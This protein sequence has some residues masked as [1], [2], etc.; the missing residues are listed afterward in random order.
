MSSPISSPLAFVLCLLSAILSE[1]KFETAFAFEEAPPCNYLQPSSCPA[2]MA[3]IRVTP[4]FSGCF[5]VPSESHLITVP[6][7]FAAGE[8]LFCDQGALSPLGNS[9]SF[10]NSGFA[11]DLHGEA[12]QRALSVYAVAEGNV[13][14]WKNCNTWNDQCGAGFGNQV[15]I[16][17][18]DGHV[19]FYAHLDWVFVNEGENVKPG[20]LLGIEGSTGWT[21]ANNRHLHFSIH[22]DW[23]QESRD[24]WRAP[25]YLPM[26]IPFLISYCANDTCDERK[27]QDVRNLP[28]ERTHPNAPPLISSGA[29]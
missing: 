28:C 2:G 18:S 24:Y 11:L 16:L 20:Q 13:S 19:Y 9:H 29:L 5:E 12:T 21:G 4:E 22:F 25:G 14:V 26:S 27:I 23:R 7:P 8:K 1:G 17:S 6:L 10:W 3:C 15:K